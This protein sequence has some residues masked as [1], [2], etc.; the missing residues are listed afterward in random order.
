MPQAI[1]AG[2]VSLL[3]RLWS[4]DVGSAPCLCPCGA[5]SLLCMKVASG[6]LWGGPF[7]F[8]RNRALNSVRHLDRAGGHLAPGGRKA[9]KGEEGGHSRWIWLASQFCPGL[10]L[11]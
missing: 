9:L 1:D 5:P 10:T 6:C 8:S 7:F 11:V 4:Q 2:S 3:P